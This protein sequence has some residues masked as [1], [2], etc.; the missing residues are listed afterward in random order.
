LSPLLSSP[1][2]SGHVPRSAENGTVSELGRHPLQ[3]DVISGFV[4]EPSGLTPIPASDCIAN[5]HLFVLQMEFVFRVNARYSVST[6][7]A[8]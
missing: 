3:R 1:A 2:L 4:Q 7:G 5:V 8:T 6:L